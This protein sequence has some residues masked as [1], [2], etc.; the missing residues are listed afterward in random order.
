MPTK[1]TKTTS[2][3]PER[4]TPRLSLSVQYAVAESALPTRGQFRRWIKA[5]LTGHSAAHAQITLRIVGSVEGRQLN[6]RYRR[7][8]HATNVL[9]FGYKVGNDMEPSTRQRK[10]LSGDIVLCAP[11]IAREA[12]DQRK[13]LAAHYAHL[14]VHGMLHLQGYDHQRDS[15][16]NRMERLESAIL[17]RLGWP[18]P[19]L[20][21]ALAH[22]PFV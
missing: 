22:G 14:T 1:R 5:A 16:A 8:P 10:I 15:D 21:G 7:Q 3:K 18:N 9:S 13:T 2:R 6:T 19:Y 17:G 20:P 4:A 11:V 12:R